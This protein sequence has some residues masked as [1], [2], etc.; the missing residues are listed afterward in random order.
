M[1]LTLGN[2]TKKNGLLPIFILAPRFQINKAS[3]ANYQIINEYLPNRNEESGKTTRSV[4][5]KSVNSKQNRMLLHAVFVDQ[6]TGKGKQVT[7]KILVNAIFPA[8]PAS[9]G[10]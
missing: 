6:R 5:Q 7:D 8:L 2:K 10:D 4:A 3:S 1:K 9:L